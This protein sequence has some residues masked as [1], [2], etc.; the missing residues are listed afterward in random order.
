MSAQ[1]YIGEIT[2]F[3][4]NFAPSGNAFCAGQL[5][6]IAENDALYSLLGTTYGGDGQTTFGL[7]DMRGRVPTGIGQGA[8]LSNVQ[9]GQLAGAET[10]TLTT[11]EMPSHT[12]T[13]AFTASTADA[14]T[15]TPVAN[16]VFGK[17]VDALGS[18]TPKIYCPAGTAATV[19]LAGA[20][21]GITA[22]AGSSQPFSLLQ[23]ILGVNFIIALFGVYPSA[24]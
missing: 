23:P 10:H 24:T 13:V 21:G 6:Q 19:A 2:I 3:A 15:Q 20:S 14:T 12:H 18:A 16:S 1:P 11:N 17:G 4:G 8:G 22:A 9:L 5:L 7:P